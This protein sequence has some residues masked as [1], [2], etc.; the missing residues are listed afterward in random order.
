MCVRVFHYL[1]TPCFGNKTKIMALLLSSIYVV[2]EAVMFTG[3][4]L[5]NYSFCAVGMYIV[6]S[7][8]SICQ[9]RSV[10]EQSRTQIST[11]KYTLFAIKVVHLLAPTYP[12]LF[13]LALQFG[14][15]SNGA[16]PV[17]CGLACQRVCLF[18][19]WVIVQN[20]AMK[21]SHRQRS[22]CG[23][24]SSQ[25]NCYRLK[26]LGAIQAITMLLRVSD[27]LRIF[28]QYMENI[29]SSDFYQ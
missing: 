5:V 14:N 10:S 18:D 12:H 4:Y 22:I 24:T 26:A 28:F 7:L 23:D 15:S 6:Y 1:V 19:F 13:S 27:T 20:T 3:W 21:M 29:T 16:W 2:F 8:C 17:F 25:L 9:D 11:C